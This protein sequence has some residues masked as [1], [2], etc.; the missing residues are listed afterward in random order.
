MYEDIITPDAEVIFKVEGEPVAIV[1]F[2]RSGAQ[3]VEMAAAILDTS[4]VPF[5]AEALKEAR[6]AIE[7]AEW[8]PRIVP[9]DQDVPV[10][11]NG[12]E[13]FPF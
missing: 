2:F 6:G 9:P 10:R 12:G 13:E 7:G 8:S 11:G 5:V 4:Y 1:A 3:G